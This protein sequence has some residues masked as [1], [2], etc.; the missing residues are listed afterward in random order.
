M[1]L[2]T[3][4]GPP[5][6]NWEREWKKEFPQYGNT[7]HQGPPVVHSLGECLMMATRDAAPWMCR[8]GDQN[9][10]QSLWYGVLGH[11]VY[12]TGCSDTEA[13]RF[14]IGMAL[15]EILEDEDGSLAPVGP[16]FNGNLEV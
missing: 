7:G 3:V 10:V 14:L 12:S 5:W 8:Q 13:R 6:E 9:K 1:V 16:I 15:Q 4:W 2:K 11:V